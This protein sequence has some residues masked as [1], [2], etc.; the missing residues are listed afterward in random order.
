MS[1]SV[2]PSF[3][4]LMV[5]GGLPLPLQA[6]LFTGTAEVA[7]VRFERVRSE[8][9]QV[10]VEVDVRSAP[11]NPARFVDRLRVRLNLGFRVTVGGDRWEFYQAESTA[12]TVAQGKAH[13]RFYLPP[14]VVR[15]DRLSGAAD[16]WAVQLAL[17]GQPVPVTRRQVSTTL[18]NPTVLENFLARVS[19]EA[20]ANAGVLVPQHLSPF[21]DADLGR[22]TPSFLRP[23]AAV[24]G[25]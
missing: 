19:A 13:F 15:R 6:N 3:I 16:Y 25:P 12:V 2:I 24:E 23:E 9:Y 4:L 1:P 10:D 18:P 5:L 20:P 22:G 7:Q 8:W 11:E 14:E 17:G 21:A